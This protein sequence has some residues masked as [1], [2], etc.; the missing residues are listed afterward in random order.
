MVKNE[1]CFAPY[2]G[3]GK[4]QG[5]GDSGLVIDIVVKSK[6]GI[7]TCSWTCWEGLMGGED[8]GGLE[9][10]GGSGRRLL[11]FCLVAFDRDL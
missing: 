6:G 3:G 2:C 4:Q 5:H 7:V 9:V 10:N 8:Y 1:C 11:W